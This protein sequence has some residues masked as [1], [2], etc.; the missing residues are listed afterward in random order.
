MAYT[1]YMKGV[2]LKL[3]APDLR[4]YAGGAVAAECAAVAGDGE[5]CAAYWRRAISE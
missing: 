5:P 2:S 3:L 4:Q 1:I